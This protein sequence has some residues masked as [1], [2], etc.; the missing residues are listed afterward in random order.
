M[1]KLICRMPASPSLALRVPAHEVV[2]NRQM[3]KPEIRRMGGILR[4]LPGG[5]LFPR[6]SI[7]AMQSAMSESARAWD[8]EALLP[9]QRL[10]ATLAAVGLQA[11]SRHTHYLL[12]VALAHANLC[13]SK[14]SQ[15][16]LE[17]A[18]LRG[19]RL[20]HADLRKTVLRSAQLE[21][22]MFWQANLS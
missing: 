16:D 9:T 8:W 7:R 21:G 20:D 13:D 3:T 17:G 18:D 15:C 1:R 2:S 14:L 4:Q 22:A 6:P 12:G 5:C 19:A 10:W 11:A